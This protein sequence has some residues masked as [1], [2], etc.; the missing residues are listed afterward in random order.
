MK[1]EKVTPAQ[2]GQGQ[3]RKN[4][5]LV[6]AVFVEW[7]AMPQK[8]RNPETQKA[9]AEVHGVTEKTLCAW[10]RRPWFRERILKLVNDHAMSRYA[11]VMEGVIE[12]AISGNAHAQK[13]YLQ[14]VM[15]WR[16]NSEISVRVNP[17]FEL[18]FGEE[19]IRPEFFTRKK[20]DPVAMPTNEPEKLN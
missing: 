8:F 7:C 13:L 16:E 1:K 9:F 12:S 5:D 4:R 10:K 14:Y 2:P 18:N 15:G 3:G 20:P 11:D 6:K 17:E 19:N